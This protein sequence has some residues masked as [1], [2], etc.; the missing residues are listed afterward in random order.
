MSNPIPLEIPP[1]PEEFLIEI[2][3][4]ME[5]Y[6]Y[7]QWFVCA[8]E[9]ADS[10]YDWYHFKHSEIDSLFVRYLREKVKNLKDQIDDD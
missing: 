4:I 7:G 9:P 8:R 3:S 6:G 1:T 2:E 5:K 10:E